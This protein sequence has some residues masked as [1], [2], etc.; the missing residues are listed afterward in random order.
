MLEREAQ[1][2]FELLEREMARAGK[3]LDEELPVG[4]KKTNASGSFRDISLSRSQKRQ[5][6]DN[7]QNS[8]NLSPDPP[9]FDNI[10]SASPIPLP[11]GTAS[12]DFTTA[13]LTITTNAA[14]PPSSAKVPASAPFSFGSTASSPAPSSPMS[15][16]SPSFS[17]PLSTPTT[18]PF[19]ALN[20]PAMPLPE[21]T[22]APLLNANVASLQAKYGGRRRASVAVWSDDRLMQFA[23][24]M[25]EKEG[26]DKDKHASKI[27][28]SLSFGAGDEN[29]DGESQPQGPPAQPKEDE[30][31]YG[32]LGRNAMFRVFH[33]LDFRQKMRVRR[34]SMVLL[35]LMLD[36]ETKLTTDVDL[37]LWHKKIDD[38]I[39]GDV[40]CFCGRVLRKLNLKGCWQVTDKGLASM[41]IYAPNLEILNLNSVWDITD[42]GLISL[43]RS[44]GSLKDVDLSN[45]R[46]LGDQG[47][48]G[49]LGECAGLQILSV[50]YCKNLTDAVMDGMGWRRLEKVCFQR[51]TGIFDGG[52]ERWR[53]GVEE[54]ALK[55]RG[56]IGTV[57]DEAKVAGEAVDGLQDDTLRRDGVREDEMVEDVG[58][59]AESH[60]IEVFDIEDTDVTMESE[61]EDG[62]AAE[63]GAAG[64]GEFLTANYFHASPDASS[65]NMDVDSIAH[66]RS[67]SHVTNESELRDIFPS[68]IAITPQTLNPY[69]FAMTELVLS[70]CSFLTDATVASIAA[71]CPAL[72]TLSL[73]FCCA[74]TEGFAGPLK[75]GCRFLRILD[76]SFCGGA[77]TDESL[78]VLCSPPSLAPGV[79]G[80]GFPVVGG[81]NQPQRPSLNQTLR[82]LSIRGCVQVTDEGIAVLEKWCKG[83]RMINVS[84]CKGVT[85]DGVKKIGWRLLTC[86]GLLEVEDDDDGFWPVQR[87]RM[88]GEGG[89]GEGKR[90]RSRASTA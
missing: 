59:K 7:R 75:E 36:P 58:E 84:Q 23:A 57:L 46:K 60:E 87:G 1:D 27:P 81:G 50:S 29:F 31:G 49:L 86:Q 25:A 73:S 56:D 61:K 43:A 51:C 16:A 41:G 20:Q 19:Q 67:H 74:L 34:T 66:T 18:S 11:Q 79:D 22:S 35:R 55:A 3:K 85:V 13:A 21:A 10:V 53:R 76:L 69:G 12:E 38:K 5:S 26:K 44:C 28:S 83:L 4:L 90:E 88:V 89:R 40:V 2:R 37:S 62:A 54:E 63:N 65:D 47:V 24:G 39:V 52:F 15:P 72:R 48:L 17:S 77:V 70:D 14:P 32:V 78:E 42:A 30:K 33:Y 80:Y 82:R 8:F 68:A 6:Y 64:V 71:S 9:T 45:C